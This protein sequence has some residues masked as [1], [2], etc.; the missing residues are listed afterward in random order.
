M[1]LAA[2][3]Q[4]APLRPVRL[5]RAPDGQQVVLAARDDVLAV[6]GPADAGQ[7]AVVGVVEGEESVEVGVRGW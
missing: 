7:A 3:D 4:R 6:G 2:R 5:A 1:P